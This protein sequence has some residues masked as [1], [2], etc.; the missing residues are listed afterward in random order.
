MLNRQSLILLLA[1]VL[2]ISGCSNKEDGTE[3]KQSLMKTTQP[4]PIEISYEQKDDS[5][6]YQI[7]KEVKD[8]DELYDV[9]V[10]E[11][12]K[13]LIVAYKVKHLKRFGMKKIEKK[14]RKQL[15]K[16]HP[17]KEFIVSSD[18]K[19]FLEVIRL[20]EALEDGNMS[21]DEA[22]KRFDKIIKLKKEMT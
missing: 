20:R 17:D 8:I 15:E 12:K 1:V 22:E 3:A 13:K 9:A 18:Y 19:I 10:I 21:A 11:H 14:L 5:I 4:A 2:L 7:R 6:A 16:E